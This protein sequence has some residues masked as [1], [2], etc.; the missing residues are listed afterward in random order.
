MCAWS[1]GS[2]ETVSRGIS[3]GISHTYTGDADP[4]STTGWDSSTY[5][6][7]FI[8]FPSSRNTV[9]LSQFRQKLRR[10]AKHLTVEEFVILRQRYDAIWDEILT[11]KVTKP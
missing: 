11:G 1:Y 5:A 10:A 4:Q 3:Q 8:R 6:G 2:S 7:D 9:D